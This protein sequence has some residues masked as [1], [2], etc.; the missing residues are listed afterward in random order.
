MI[1]LPRSPAGQPHLNFYNQNFQEKIQR[2]NELPL[3]MTTM[4]FDKF[5][6]LLILNVIVFDHMV[7]F[8][9]VRLCSH[10]SHCH[11]LT[12]CFVVLVII[13]SFSQH[14]SI[15]RISTSKLLNSPFLQKILCIY[16]MR[17][18]IINQSKFFIGIQDIPEENS[19]L[20][21]IIFVSRIESADIGRL[22]GIFSMF[23]ILSVSSGTGKGIGEVIWGTFMVHGNGLGTISLIIQGLG[24]IW[25]IH[26]NL[27]EIGAK[28]MTMGIIVRK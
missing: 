15:F 6:F 2:I 16:N 4:K 28:A 9:N 3:M 8:L 11:W 14:S 18:N 27:Q 17:S 1:G 26:G 7:F 20:S 25:A 13:N 24:S 19:T 12:Q 22:T 21:E 10:G 23:Q 5:Y